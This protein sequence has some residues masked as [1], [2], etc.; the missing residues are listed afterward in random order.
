MGYLPSS[1]RPT[2]NSTW[3]DS[4]EEPLAWSRS[5]TACVFSSSRQHSWMVRKC[6]SSGCFSSHSVT[7]VGDDFG[8]RKRYDRCILPMSASASGEFGS[9]KGEGES[10]FQDTAWK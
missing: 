2:G 8:S 4:R 3:R 5:P 10:C 9:S 1:V 7:S 6:C